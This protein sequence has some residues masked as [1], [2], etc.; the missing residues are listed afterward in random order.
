MMSEIL[1]IAPTLS[2]EERL[3]LVVP[4]VHRLIAG[5]K[6]V[7]SEPE[8]AAIRRCPTKETWKEY[9][10]RVMLL[11]WADT[12][13]LRDWETERL[14][15]LCLLTVLRY[16]MRLV[17]LTDGGDESED[18]SLETIRKIVAGANERAKDF[19]AYREAVPL[20][21][22]EVY[23]LPL[24]GEATKTRMTESYEHVENT[25]SLHNETVRGIVGIP[26]TE[27]FLKPMIEE[28][29]NYLIREPV[30]DPELVGKMVADIRE[31]AEADLRTRG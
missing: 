29:E 15:V 7:L 31:I 13:W 9:A 21:E 16:E 4:D 3:R 6:P 1:K 28:T 24:F 17:G 11:K 26:G 14:R 5:E 18:G 23:G 10:Y 27:E 25:I 20:L 22:R 8:F 30:P 12:V 2:A 19:F